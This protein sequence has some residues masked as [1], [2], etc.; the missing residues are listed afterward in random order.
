MVP[1]S[2]KRIFLTIASEKPKSAFSHFSLLDPCVRMAHGV[3]V[4]VAGG[5]AHTSLYVPGAAPENLPRA[6][7]VRCVPCS[8]GSS[9]FIHVVAS[10]T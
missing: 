8:A 6:I 3:C 2:E 5:S 1:T 7:W 9:D 10:L 4:A